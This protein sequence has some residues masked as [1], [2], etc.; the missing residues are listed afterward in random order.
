MS[1]LNISAAEILDIIN[2]DVP[3][4]NLMK[5]IGI[6][7]TRSLSSD[8][9]ISVGVSYEDDED[10][11][12]IYIYNVFIDDEYIHISETGTKEDR[13]PTAVINRILSEI[14]SIEI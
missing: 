6:Y 14:S 9:I 1:V 2:K 11:K 7:E 10:N 5:N 13:L 4:D 12:E 3:F 8:L